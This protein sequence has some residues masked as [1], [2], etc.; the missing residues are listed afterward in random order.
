MSL[1]RGLVALGV[2]GYSS[3][4]F[5]LD[6]LFPQWSTDLFT[7]HDPTKLK[8]IFTVMAK[9]GIPQRE[10]QNLGVYMGKTNR[11]LG[12]SFRYEGKGIA[13]LSKVTLFF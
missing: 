1:I 8:A 4:H 3:Y 2:A 9:M 13:H 7:I 6:T 11:F 12:A 10:A 5:A